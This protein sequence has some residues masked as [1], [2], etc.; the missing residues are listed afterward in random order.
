MAET[1]RLIQMHQA[2]LCIYQGSLIDNL[3]PSLSEVADQ[4]IYSCSNP[5]YVLHQYFT[6]KHG[7]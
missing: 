1:S 5:H 2:N 6:R 4:H 7:G 3:H